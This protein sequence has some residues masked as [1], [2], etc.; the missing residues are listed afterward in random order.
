ML[1][2]CATKF[3]VTENLEKFLN[4]Q[5]EGLVDQVTER[6]VRSKVQWTSRDP[7]RSSRWRRHRA[8]KPVPVA[9][10]ICITSPGIAPKRDRSRKLPHLMPVRRMRRPPDRDPAIPKPTCGSPSLS[11]LAGRQP[12]K[13]QLFW[14]RPAP[15]Q[16]VG[17]APSLSPS[18]GAR[19][20][21][22][23]GLVAR[24]PAQGM[25]SLELEPQLW[26]LLHDC[27]A[28]V[29]VRSGA[30]HYFTT[31]LAGSDGD[32][33]V[34]CA[35]TTARRSE[36]IRPHALFLARTVAVG[37][38]IL[39]LSLY[40]T[41]WTACALLRLKLKYRDGVAVR[42][43][44]FVQVQLDAD[45]PGRREPGRILSIKSKPKPRL[46]FN[47]M[48]SS[49]KWAAHRGGTPSNILFSSSFLVL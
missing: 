36:L 8:A 14:G 16:V 29:V 20:H 28:L 22:T 45:G 3:D 6:R 23:P 42:S 37:V 48:G 44:I 27:A 26:P 34:A 32:G 11:P 40:P 25:Q 35:S 49:G 15:A 21:I 30:Q 13:T 7:S 10:P 38:A 12:D 19:P 2:V 5:S 9:I 43:W 17:G 47:E 41:F 4:F 33:D 24:D 1:H 18:C 46:L 39:L 31:P